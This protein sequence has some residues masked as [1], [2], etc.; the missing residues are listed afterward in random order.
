MGFKQIRRLVYLAALGVFALVELGRSGT[1][2][3]TFLFYTY[4]RGKA[5]VEDRTLSRSPSR[6]QDITRYVEETLLGPVSLNSAPLVNTGTKLRSLLFRN[7]T[8]FADLEESAALQVPE[9]KTGV[10]EGMTTLNRGIRRNFPYVNAVKLFIDGHEIFY[11]E[12][13]EIFE[14]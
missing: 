14:K 10:L 9:S 5:V 11:R 6:E 2:R 1:V 12:F 7:G 4:D 8:V 13:S 3:R